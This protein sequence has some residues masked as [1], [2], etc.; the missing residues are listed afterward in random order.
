MKINI[1]IT[2][3]IKEPKGDSIFSNGIRQNVILLQEMYKKCKNVDESYI[4]NVLDTDPSLYKNTVWEKY[5]DN[6]ISIKEI[7]EKC[8]IIVICHGS[9]SHDVILNLKNKG[10][11]VV[12]Q[13]L[14]AEL[15]IFNETILF[16]SEPY[17]IYKNNSYTDATWISPHFYERDRFFYETRYRCQSYEAPYI[18]DSRFIESHVELHKKSDAN[19]IVEYFPKS[20]QKRISVI[21]PNLNMVK[22]S[23][24]PIVISELFFRKHPDLIQKVSIFG[25]EKLKQKKDVIDFV[26]GL[27]IHKGKK[28]F[29]ESRFPIVWTL[30]SHTDILLSHQ[31][32]CEL[33]YAYLDAAW[34]G[35][36]VV[37]N[38]PMMKDLGWYYPG[39]NATIAME[40]LEYIIRNFDTVEH[41]NNKYLN[42]SRKFAYRYS[43][44][45]PDN[46]HG[47]EVLID[48]VINKK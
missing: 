26:T 41:P 28:I 14:G 47:Y 44:D 35:Y 27:D 9:M 33:N 31:N 12:K 24:I 15:S 10:K 36:P 38:S 11:K 17:G 23:T 2:T 21:E 7:E 22:T 6:I 42:E 29:F 13:V 39:N 1:G 25:G 8:D 37:H 45:N 5:S 48:K 18:W 32:Q 46:I 4:I 20:P 34:L 43:V 16:K 3:I 30:N 40:H 19:K